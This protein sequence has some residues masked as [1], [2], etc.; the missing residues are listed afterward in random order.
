MGGT[1]S[2]YI[3]TGRRRR[4][5]GIFADAGQL[6]AEA[7]EQLINP[8]D[9]A[10]VTGEY[11]EW[12]ALA[13]PAFA[14][15]NNR[16]I[17]ALYRPN[18]PDGVSTVSEVYEIAIGLNDEM[19]FLAETQPEIED[20]APGV[21]VEFPILSP[22]WLGSEEGRK[23]IRELLSETQ[24]KEMCTQLVTRVMS[25]HYHQ[26]PDLS[27]DGDPSIG[28][29][30]LYHGNVAK[31]MFVEKS[32]G[33]LYFNLHAWEK[34]ENGVRNDLVQLY[35]LLNSLGQEGAAQVIRSNITNLLGNPNDD[36]GETDVSNEKLASFAVE[37]IEAITPL[38]E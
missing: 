7:S 5:R 14:F 37:I 29:R 25:L 34:K 28:G 38:E 1:L 36:D 2:V 31:A 11:G 19:G 16:P 9:K 35:G 30:R 18:A 22:V 15:G 21:V 10:L 23:Q 4:R 12:K 8:S 13:I 3:P 20:E 6:G 32:T 26:F 24:M 27:G 17:M 33:R